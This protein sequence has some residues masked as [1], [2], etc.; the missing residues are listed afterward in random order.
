MMTLRTPDFPDHDAADK[1][2]SAEQRDVYRQA[3]FRQPDFHW[4]GHG[5]IAG[6][7]HGVGAA[8]GS[9]STTRMTS[10]SALFLS[11]NTRMLPGRSRRPDSSAGI[12]LIT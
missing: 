4:L 1:D 6:P 12:R 10:R 9:F 5:W 2:V 11:A 3:V 8:C 7:G